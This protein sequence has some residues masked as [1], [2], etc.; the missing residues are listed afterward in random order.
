MEK[1]LK[2]KIDVG[3]KIIEI[4]ICISIL[5]SL[6]LSVPNLVR[7]ALA[8]IKTADLKQNYEL[9]N[10]FL[11]HALLIVVG[12]EL[13]EMILTKS[14]EAIL[15]LILFV[16]ARKMLLYSVDL[17]DIL[18]GSISIGLIFAIIKFVVKDDKLMA[19]IDNTYS[20][21]VPVKKIKE[22]YKL[23]IPQNMSNTLGGL[24]YEIAKI[25]GIE[26]IKE[27]TRLIYGP[28]KFKVISMKDGVI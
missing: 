16:I 19:K 1:K 13:I 9:L 27:N 25:E 21:S 7:Y 17:I 28:Y 24:V 20:A 26:E 23:N 22:E 12:I 6:I 15:T 14:H 5:F 18:I 2:E 10:E 8:I 3:I 11:K 4:I